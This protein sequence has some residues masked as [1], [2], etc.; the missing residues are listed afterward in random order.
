VLDSQP[1]SDAPAASDE[2]AGSDEAAPSDD[3]QA[4]VST[5]PETKDRSEAAVE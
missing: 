2:A 4:A 3:A 5:A 1:G